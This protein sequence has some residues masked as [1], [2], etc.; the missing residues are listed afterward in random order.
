MELEIQRLNE[1]E[2]ER[3]REREKERESVPQRENFQ[4]DDKTTDELSLH[5][6]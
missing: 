6:G 5:L 1:K 3:E 4:Y 2:R